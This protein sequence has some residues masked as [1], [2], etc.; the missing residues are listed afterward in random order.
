MT[1]KIFLLLLCAFTLSCCSKTVPT[2]EDNRLR[3]VSDKTVIEA[4]QA[5]D[6]VGA[7]QK[8]NAELR[9]VVSSVEKTK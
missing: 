1:E 9:D 3:T 6:E 2:Y 8:I 5:E 4:K 7:M